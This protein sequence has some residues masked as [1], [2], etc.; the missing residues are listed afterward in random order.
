MGEKRGSKLSLS[1]CREQRCS[2]SLLSRRE[3]QDFHPCTKPFELVSAGG[4]TGPPG[5]VFG[6]SLRHYLT[7][8]NELGLACAREFRP[9]ALMWSARGGRARCQNAFFFFLLFLFI[10]FL[11]SSSADGQNTV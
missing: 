7:R 11:N 4:G 2:E 10:L 5:L 9:P 1:L 6:S 8:E 3:N